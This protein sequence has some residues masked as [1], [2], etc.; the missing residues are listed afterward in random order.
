MKF[1][2]DILKAIIRM[3]SEGKTPH[4]IALELNMT[5]DELKDEREINEKLNDA[6]TRAEF[7]EDQKLISKLKKQALTKIDNGQ[8]E[9]LFRLMDKH[10]YS[11]D[12][13]IIIEEVE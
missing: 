5:S 11:S 3:G 2:S 13:K 12:N 6:M 4:D 10:N 1:T 9:L 8:K 7:N